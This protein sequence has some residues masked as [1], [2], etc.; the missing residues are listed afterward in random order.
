MNAATGIIAIKVTNNKGTYAKKSIKIYSILHL[1]SPVRCEELWE[2]SR[3]YQSSR[4]NEHDS[5]LL[6]FPRSYPL[7]EYE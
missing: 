1:K 7:D 4:R 5:S 3:S 6:T 2:A